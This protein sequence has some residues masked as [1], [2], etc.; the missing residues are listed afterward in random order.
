MDIAVFGSQFDPLVSEPFQVKNERD[1]QK[2]PE[3]RR[4]YRQH[5]DTYL[6]VTGKI[7]RPVFAE[8]TNLNGQRRFVG[9]FEQALAAQRVEY[10]AGGKLPFRHVSMLTVLNHLGAM[11]RS[12]ERT[13]PRKSS[14]S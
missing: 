1:F 13:R 11:Y 8:V 9:L 12:M 4:Y 6:F 10:M 3:K 5:G 2:V 7:C 14:V